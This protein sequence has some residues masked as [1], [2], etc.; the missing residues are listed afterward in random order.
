M[1][2]G[3]DTGPVARA[4]TISIAQVPRKDQQ[5][6]PCLS[7]CF[8][9]FLLEV[10]FYVIILDLIIVNFIGRLIRNIAIL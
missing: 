4:A 9:I 6:Q 5:W 3:G 2:K 10:V 1:H 7:I 8:I